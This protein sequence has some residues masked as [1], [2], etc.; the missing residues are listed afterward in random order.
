[1]SPHGRDRSPEDEANDIINS[2]DEGVSD[3]L[4]GTELYNDLADEEEEER[5][6]VD[7]LHG[8]FAEGDYDDE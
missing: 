4:E 8:G 1:M 7:E 2:S 6:L 5:D 3:L